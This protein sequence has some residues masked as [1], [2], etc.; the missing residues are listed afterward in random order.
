MKLKQIV[1]SSAAVLTLFT[2]ST[3][4][5]SAAVQTQTVRS[6][7]TYDMPEGDVFDPE[8]AGSGNHVVRTRIPIGDKQLLRE[9]AQSM[10]MPEALSDASEQPAEEMP[11]EFANVEPEADAEGATPVPNTL[12]TRCNTNVATGFAPSDIHG[13]TGYSKLVVVTNVDIGVYQNSNCSIVSRVALK[14]MFSSFS[15]ISNQTL[16]DP[17]VIFDRAAGRFFV[18]VESRD[19][20]SGNTDQYQY[21][22][23]STSSLA[24]GWHLYRVRLS[25]GTS[26]FCKVATNSFWDYPGAGKNRTR[27]LLTANDFP[28]TGGVSGAIMSIDKT[29]TLSGGSTS[30]K[31]WNN[32]PYNIQPPIVLDSDSRATFLYPR[33]SSIGRYVLT[34][35][36]SLSGD[37]LASTSSLSIPSWSAPPDAV[38]PNGE[39]LD[40]LDGRFQ[41]ASIQSRGQIWNIHTIASGSRPVI[42]WYRLSARGTSRSYYTYSGSSTY[43]LFN[44]SFT[45]S[46]GRTGAPAFINVSRTIPSC[47]SSY[48]RAAMLVGAGHNNS[49]SSTVWSWS[50]A[51]YSTSQFTGCNT[52]SRGSCRW[53]DYSSITVHPSEAGAAWGFNQLSNGSSMWNWFTRAAKKLYNTQY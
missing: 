37:S 12:S 14:S 52:Q 29:P 21:F 3:M 28:A 43:H 48:C 11:D 19:N 8:V 39:R 10:S 2:V 38:Q 15:D 50:S 24:S 4:S 44:P 23:V 42:R 7:G 18:T 17:R 30:A 6:H 46:S 41:S 1:I 5:A 32:L 51:G 34:T 36:S 47:S 53:G 27:W 35:G 45:T 22:A 40:S 31:C 13:A 9:K 26:R 33:S 16:F 20:R 49:S 25:Q